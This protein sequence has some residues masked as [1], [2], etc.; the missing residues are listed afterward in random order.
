MAVAETLSYDEAMQF[1]GNGKFQYFQM[2][3]SGFS[4]MA[5]ITEGLNMAF[6]LPS[7]KCELTYSVAMQSMIGAIGFIGVILS[8]HMWGFLNDTWGRQK[9]LRA[10]LASSFIFSFISSMSVSGSMLLVTRFFVGFW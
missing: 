5:V 1:I 4:L 2:F 3:V 6:V 10:A 9:V 8:S 7:A